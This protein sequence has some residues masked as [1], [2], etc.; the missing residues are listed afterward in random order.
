M[1]MTMTLDRNTDHATDL[2]TI[3]GEVGAS[4]ERFVRRRISDPHQANDVVAEVMLRIHQ[5]LGTL[6]DQRTGHGM[7]VPHHPKCD[8]R[9]LPPHWSP[10]GSTGP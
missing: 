3:W 10:P 9:S 7:G 1:G 5:N 6:D 4:I 2:D 8:H